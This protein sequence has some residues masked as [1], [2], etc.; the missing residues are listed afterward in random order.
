M[1]T[2]EMT[3][4]EEDQFWLEILELNVPQNSRRLIDED[5]E[6]SSQKHGNTI[7]S[8]VLHGKY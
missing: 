2:D 7:I 6:W 8:H 4:E 5:E 3:E 1:I